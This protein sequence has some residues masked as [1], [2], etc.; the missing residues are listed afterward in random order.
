MNRILSLIL[1]LTVWSINGCRND[2]E[3]LFAGSGVIE[4]TEILVSAET[5]GRLI[6]IFFD[7]GDYLYKDAVIAEIDVERIEL[8][9]EV[10]SADMTELNWSEKVI[11]KEIAVAEELVSQASISLDNVQKTRDR[12]SNLYKQNAATK[13]NLDKAETELS[14]CISKLHTTEKQLDEVKTRAASLHAKREKIE[15]NL[16]LLDS[17]IKDGKVIC[18]HDG[19]MIEKYV[20]NGE[21]VN[22]GIPICKIADLSTVWLKIYVGEEMLGNL[23]IGGMAVINVDSHPERNFDGRITWISQN[24]EFT[25]KNVQTKDSRVDLVYAIKITM[26]NP[27][28]IFKIGMPAD[29]HIEGL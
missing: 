25:P 2:E 27:E 8:Q 28:G 26:E 12:M 29:V 23:A 9:K 1:L 21:I 5:Q 19:I 15:A 4:A 6:N 13:E 20:E 10:A 16:R 3:N 18:P 17:M 22:F 11:D 24:A 7:E 14:L